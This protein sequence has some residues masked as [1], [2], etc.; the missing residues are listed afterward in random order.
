MQH[1][2]Q[3]KTE[4]TPMTLA[5]LL[6]FHPIP[7]YMT[8]NTQTLL[9]MGGWSDIETVRKFYLKNTDENEKR[10]VKVLDN[11]MAGKIL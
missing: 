2:E 7:L 8:A 4:T 11:L 10:A 3:E 6:D 5:L 9:K 1:S